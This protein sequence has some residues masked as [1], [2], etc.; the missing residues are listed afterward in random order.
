MSKII[1]PAVEFYRVRL[2]RLDATEEP[3]FEWRDDVL[4][5]QMPPEVPQ[6]RVV[7]V[8]EA[9]SLDESETV[10]EIERFDDADAA[11]E[12]LGRV[13]E[14]MADLTKSGFEER[15]LTAE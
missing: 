7:W 9:V 14:D 15:Y 1:G 3:D 13:E 10:T 12:C 4:Y 5:R 2:T 6:E 11:H 8:V